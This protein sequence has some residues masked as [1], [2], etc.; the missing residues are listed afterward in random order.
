MTSIQKK[1]EADTLLN[2]TTIL[3][4][5]EK[6][7]KKHPKQVKGNE[8]FVADKKSLT[9]YTCGRKG[10]LKSECRKPEK[11]KST[12]KNAGKPNK[13]ELVCFICGKKGHIKR[14]VDPKKEDQR[15]KVTWG[16][17]EQSRING[18]QTEGPHST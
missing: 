1:D 17:Q 13:R 4:D 7:L 8:S 16:P 3:L 15:A 9:C 2:F 18:L 12:A 10:H 5:A 6:N 14:T 11:E